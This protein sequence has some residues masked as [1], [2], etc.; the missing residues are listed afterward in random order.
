[1]EVSMFKIANSKK[2]L[3][4]SGAHY[5]AGITLIESIVALTIL[6]LAVSGP[7]S[8]AAQSIRVLGASRAEMIATHL[9]EEGVE[10]VH[11]LRDNN[12]ADDSTPDKSAWMTDVLSRCSGAAGFSGCIIDVTG[13]SSALGKVWDN[14]ATI[15]PCPVGGC[16]NLARIYFN[17][18]TGLYRQSSAPLGAPFEL[19][20]FRRTVVMI[21]IDDTLDPRRQVRVTATVTYVGY[22]GKTQTVR[23]SEDLYN[24]FPNLN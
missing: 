24:W 11:S 19:T 12:S 17:P 18:A 22:G 9:A 1:M 20:S 23:I 15:V 2:L 16:G 13:H 4:G 5:R 21:G 10:V 14:L 8:L 7:M 6:T 3:R